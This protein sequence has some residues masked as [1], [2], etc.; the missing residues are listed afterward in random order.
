LSKADNYQA[1]IYDLM[2]KQLANY[3][4]NSN[5]NNIDA[6]NLQSGVY[7]VQ[8]VNELTGAKFSKKLIIN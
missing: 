5:V 8:V 6:S 7:I 3:N 1:I 4:L 2:G